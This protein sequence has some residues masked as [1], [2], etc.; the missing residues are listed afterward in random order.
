MIVGR[1]DQAAGG[2]VCERRLAAGVAG[3]ARLP[4]C[5]VVVSF[6]IPAR[7]FPCSWESSLI[8]PAG[9]RPGYVYWTEPS[10]ASPLLSGFTSAPPMSIYTTPH[11]LSTVC[12]TMDII[13]ILIPTY[14]PLR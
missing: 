14:S 5:R 12:L 9:R 8:G 3:R 11:R 7:R 4:S 13:Y 10:M 2:R 6:S 1:V